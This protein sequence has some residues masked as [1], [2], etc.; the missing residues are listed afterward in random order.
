MDIDP[1]INGFQLVTRLAEQTFQFIQPRALLG[2]RLKCFLVK[3]VVPVQAPGKA[4]AVTLIHA[5]EQTMVS[6]CGIGQEFCGHILRGTKGTRSVETLQE[7]ASR[8]MSVDHGAPL[9]W[10]TGHD[11]FHVFLK[12][13]THFA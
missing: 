11:F 4:E 2:K 13:S 12:R 7:K 3:C 1:T 6:A 9:Y 5:I 10:L 8:G